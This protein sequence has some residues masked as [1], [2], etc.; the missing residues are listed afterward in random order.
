MRGGDHAPLASYLLAVTGF[1]SLVPVSGRVTTFP[2]SACLL[3]VAWAF[4]E[5]RTAARLPRS[6]ARAADL[7]T[8]T[9]LLGLAAALMA[10]GTGPLLALSR[11]LVLAQLSRVA[12]RK[13]PKDLAVLHGTALGQVALAAFLTRS[14]LYLPLL[15]AAVVLGVVASLRLRAGPEPGAGDVRIFLG[16]PRGR[17]GFRARVGAW[18]LPVVL[19]LGL[20]LA[21]LTLF[22]LLPRGAHFRWR[23]EPE[24]ATGE[25]VDPT[26]YSR[27]REDA[28]ERITGF[29]ASVELGEVGRIKRVPREAFRVKLT[30]EGRPLRLK[31]RHLYFRGAVLDTFTGHGW[32]RSAM[33]GKD[34]G[35]LLG[36]PESSR[37]PI[38]PELT[39]EERAGVR[40]IAQEYRMKAAT[41]RILLTIGTVLSFELSRELPWVLG[42]GGDSFG[43]PRPHSEGFG[44][45]VTSLVAH[46]PDL[47]AL[48]E[49]L[50]PER[51]VPYLVLASVPRRA[52]LLARKVAGEGSAL[53]KAERIR[54]HLHATC[55]YTLLFR[56]RPAGSPLEHFLFET[57]AGHCEY[58][59]TAQAVMLRAVG[60][61]TRLVAGYRGGLWLESEGCYFVRMSDAHAWVEAHVPG[62]G[63]VTL[64]PTPADQDAVTV[65][66]SRVPGAIAIGAPPDLADRM[67]SLV[68][69]FGTAERDELLSAA[70]RGVGF[71]IREGFGPGREDRP[72]PPPGLV[73]V[74]AAF[75]GFVGAKL[76][77]LLPRPGR[78]SDAA[79]GGRVRKPP[80]EAPFYRQAVRVLAADGVIRSAQSTPREF[81][82]S[83]LA[84][85]GDRAEPFREITAAF[86]SVRYGGLVLT[87]EDEVALRGLV[88]RLSERLAAGQR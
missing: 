58:F 64:D 3:L 30:R 27:D 35:K 83:A 66:P 80:P 56:D 61:P 28:V 7:L 31:P 69:D 82:G 46:A 55:E 44:Y 53:E 81:L 23:T 62:R 43:A 21:G 87:G 88:G 84:V 63:W 14:P 33:L 24:Q 79:K 20:L 60:V 11:V 37:L 51:A 45:A 41:S 10:E 47:P 15:L 22:V 68:T 1:L 25:V 18:A 42:L 57:R 73:L 49:E 2:A 6:V 71:L 70:G 34:G 39:A 16:R 78:R 52:V 36:G 8:V 13:E 75:V 54:E 29:S 74:V 17:A 72:F 67:V 9:C 5:R 40:L 4:V 38:H 76:L 59:A 12:R 86:E 50:S 77:G 32:A 26:D 85:R 48:E 19:T 65:D